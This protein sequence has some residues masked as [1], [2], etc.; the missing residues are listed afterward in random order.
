MSDAFSMNR[1]CMQW[2]EGHDEKTSFTPEF[3]MSV[4][5]DRD[6]LIPHVRAIHPG[7]VGIS[8]KS[9]AYFISYL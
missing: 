5:D 4:S 6:P 9:I 3:I 1:Q 8:I 2:E 7:V